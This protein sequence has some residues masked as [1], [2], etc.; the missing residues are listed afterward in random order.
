VLG[1]EPGAVGARH[2]RP[3]HGHWRILRDA[4]NDRSA[5]RAG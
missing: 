5:L 4:R 2:P 1:R 3:Q